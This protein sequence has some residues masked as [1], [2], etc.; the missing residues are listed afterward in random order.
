MRKLEPL[1]V[2]KMS[3]E[4]LAT[5]VVLSLNVG[6]RVPTVT[7]LSAGVVGNGPLSPMVGM[8]GWT[9]GSG[10]A[11]TATLNGPFRATVTSPPSR[12]TG[13]VTGATATGPNGARVGVTLTNPMVA[14]VGGVTRAG[15]AA[16]VGVSVGSPRLLQGRVCAG[17]PLMIPMRGAFCPEVGV[18]DLRGNSTGVDG[19]DAGLECRGLDLGWCRS[20]AAGSQGADG[21]LDGVCLTCG[22]RG[23]MVLGW[24]RVKVGW[25]VAMPTDG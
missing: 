10:R 11:G 14:A 3:K 16:S 1:L 2:G 21:R 4:Q 13:A 25:T 6:L 20:D 22:I 7:G 17:V 8:T 9:N 5:S 18:W 23:V 19:S 12:S 15:S 24:M